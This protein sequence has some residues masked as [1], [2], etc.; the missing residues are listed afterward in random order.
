MRRDCLVLVILISIVVTSCGEY[1][2]LEHQKI[3]KRRADSTYRAHLKDFA[4]EADSLC[5]RNKELYYQN[6][7][8]SMIPL[9]IEEMKKLIAR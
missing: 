8:D 9:R 3:C 4:K 6:A 5:I 1:E 7:L 2:L